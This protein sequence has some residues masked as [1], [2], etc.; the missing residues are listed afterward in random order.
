MDTV[1]LIQNHI[2]LAKRIIRKYKTIF[3]DLDVTDIES[4]VYYALFKAS[5]KYDESKGRFSTYAWRCME[6]EVYRLARTRLPKEVE[7]MSLFRPIKKQKEDKTQVIDTIDAERNVI[8]LEDKLLLQDCIT[9]MNQEERYLFV[10]YYIEGKTYEEL[11]R[12]F[13]CTY[14]NI[15]FKIRTLV[16]KI[17]KY[18]TS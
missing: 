9:S 1:A 16:K 10:S 12:E 14:Q 2:K 18:A 13:D 5:L 17:K 7:V 8:A 6:I 4:A 15:Q 3:Y 11:A